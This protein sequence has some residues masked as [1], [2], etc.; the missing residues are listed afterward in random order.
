MS[1]ET[2]DIHRFAAEYHAK[3]ALLD[4]AVKA[5]EAECVEASQ[6]GD[7]GT[8]GEVLAAAIR[9]ILTRLRDVPVHGSKGE[10]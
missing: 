8:S 2:W 10:G 3:A 6:L 4:E 1:D 9:A 7:E 5:I